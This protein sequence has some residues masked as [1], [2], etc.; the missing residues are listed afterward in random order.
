M[1]AEETTS[2]SAMPP[3]PPANS[4]SSPSSGGGAFSSGALVDEPKYKQ[5]VKWTFIVVDIGLAVLLAATGALAMQ[6]ADGKDSDEDSNNIFL[7]LYM[8]LFA[9]ILFFYECMAACPMDMVDKFMRNNFGFMYN[10]FGRGFY[11]LFIS[12][13]CYGISKPEDMAIGSGICIGAAGVLQMLVYLKEP[14][15][16]DKPVELDVKDIQE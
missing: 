4:S 15:Y 8:V 3:A 2:T 16:F 11:M 14:N 1:D 6:G 7:G 9:A 13:M 5:L 10:V 12:V